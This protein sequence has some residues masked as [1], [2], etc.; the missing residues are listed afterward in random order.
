MRFFSPFN[1][2]SEQAIVPSHWQIC[3]GTSALLCLPAW[4]RTIGWQPRQTRT[5]RA[6]HLVELDIGPHSDI[7]ERD[8]SRVDG[9][10]HLKL[11]A[12]MARYVLRQWHVDCSADH[13]VTEQGCRL[14]LW[15]V[16]VLYGVKNAMLALGYQRMN[17]EF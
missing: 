12:V 16:L 6:R 3:T 13:N 4:N 7:T 1:G 5:P 15:D 2:E 14:W 17:L 8:Y 11:R 9:V 10:L